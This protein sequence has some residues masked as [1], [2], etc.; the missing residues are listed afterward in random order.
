MWNSKTTSSNS[1]QLKLFFR[2]TTWTWAKSPKSLPV[3]LSSCSFV[4][5]SMVRRNISI[6]KN[7]KTSLIILDEC[8]LGF[9]RWLAKEFLRSCSHVSHG[10]E[11]KPHMGGRYLEYSKN[12]DVWAF[13]LIIHLSLEFDMV[14][15]RLKNLTERSTD[16]WDSREQSRGNTR[17]VGTTDCLWKDIK[18][19]VVPALMTSLRNNNR[20]ERNVGT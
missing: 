3:W 19:H 10:G 5:L 1:A 6:M 15:G 13:W 14:F 8:P 7:R 20:A 17:P 9:I 11:K 4:F 2:Y 12:N 16:S 18:L